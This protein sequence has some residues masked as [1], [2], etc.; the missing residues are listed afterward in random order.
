MSSVN[1]DPF[2]SL[3][4]FNKK[5]QQQQ[6]LNQLLTNKSDP[7]VSAKLANNVENKQHFIVMENSQTNT[8]TYAHLNVNSSLNN[9]NKSYSTN[10]PTSSTIQQQQQ[11][12]NNT[13]TQQPLSSFTYN[14]NSTVT[15]QPRNHFNANIVNNFGGNIPQIQ[16]NKQVNSDLFFNQKQTQNLSQF[17]NLVNNNGGQLSN[18][19]TNFNNSFLINEN[20]HSI[21]NLSLN[22]S[23]MDHN[24]NQ[25]NNWDLDYLSM[26]DNGLKTEAPF[27]NQAQMNK[28]NDNPE[29]DLL[30]DL[31]KPVSQFSK[32]DVAQKPDPNLIQEHSFNNASDSNLA[33]FGTTSTSV[34]KKPSVEIKENDRNLDKNLANL[35]SMGF[36]RKEAVLALESTDYDIEKAVAILISQQN[37]LKSAIKPPNSPVSFR[38]RRVSFDSNSATKDYY[39]ETTE[40]ILT[41]ATSFGKKLFSGAKVA[42]ETTKQ[43]ISTF[44]EDNSNNNFNEFGNISNFVEYENSTSR[45]RFRDYSDD[46]SSF[47]ET[48]KPAFVRRRFDDGSPSTYNH[49]GVE[50]TSSS[51]NPVRSPPQKPPSSRTVALNSEDLQEKKESAKKS[52]PQLEISTRQLSM[53]LNYKETG[54]KFFKNGNYAS[55]EVSYTTGIQTL[56]SQFQNLENFQHTIVSQL[57]LN[58]ASSRLKNGDYS[59]CVEDCTFIF[60]CFKEGG[61]SIE[62]QKKLLLKRSE[63]L[64]KLEKFQQALEDYRS[65][66]SVGV[67]SNVV[68]DGLR[69][70][71]KSLDLKKV[72]EVSFSNIK[73]DSFDPFFS[74]TS[75]NNNIF[76][77]N[78]G[79]QQQSQ[80]NPYVNSNSYDANFENNP[81]FV[82]DKNN[83]TVNVNTNNNIYQNQTQKPAMSKFVA[84]KVNEAVQ[85]HRQKNLEKENLEDLKLALKDAIDQRVDNWKKGKEDNLRALLSSLEMILWKDLNF[86]KINLNEIILPNQVKI[87]YMKS[88]A[89]IHPDK[90]SVDCTVEEK[91]IAERVFSALNFAWDKFKVQNGI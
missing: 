28:T 82:N 43:K 66:I 52:L 50:A 13:Y 79:I 20:S 12:N 86:L 21:K 38:N 36:S 37:L 45:E 65:L 83:S 31:S 3:S 61:Y 9:F 4:S 32:P 24:P 80:Q 25:S 11:S 23:L 41:T 54:N 69:R 73:Q 77:N 1:N 85:I 78:F 55:A 15:S 90:L 40:K 64:E 7:N 84:N 26:N 5:P 39:Q 51:I 6:Q 58:R 60:N 19:H 16:Q 2:A 68:N 56:L 67:N 27:F 34:K 30:G 88:V 48:E 46:D 87:K 29:F 18:N 49:P 47:E 57:F 8:K 72:Q 75:N 74:A 14:S 81:F 44:T 22:N 63:A 42:L 59:G 91:M 10:S 62:E 71:L 76:K 35:I 17:S 33:E 70:C 89:K 53:L